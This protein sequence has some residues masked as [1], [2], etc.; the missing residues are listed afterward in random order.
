MKNINSFK[1]FESL[2][3]DKIQLLQD[4]SLELEDA[5]LQVEVINGT[6]THLLRDPRVTIHSGSKYSSDYK[7]YI[8]MRITDDNELFNADLYFTDTIQDF[9]ETLKSYGMNPRGM[10]GGRNFALIKFDKWGKMTG[11][12]FKSNPIIESKWGAVGDVQDIQHHYSIYDWFEDLKS[13]QW[14][15]KN[16]NN[17]DL[18]KWSDHF[19]GSGV[20]QKISKL[21][22]DIFNSIRSVDYN[23]INDRMLE[24]W[25]ELPTNKD[26]YVMACVAY[27]DYENLDK[28]IMYR[29]NGLLSVMNPSDDS[30]KLDII[31]HIIKDIIYPTLFIG[32]PSIPLR[33]TEEQIYVTDKKW[34]CE[35][36]DI[37]SYEFNEGEEFDN[38]GTGRRSTTTIF[39]SELD[40]K[41]NYEVDKVISM[42]KPCLVIEIGGHNDSHRTGK[43][44][45]SHLEPILDDVL[46]TILPDLDYEEVIWDKSRGKRQ[47]TDDEFYD[48]TLKI[49]LK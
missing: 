4:L 23:Y 1:I 10:S 5:G 11:S 39:K 8:I 13:I 24:V 20:Y 36:F 42:Y 21:V 3:D 25:D 30:K 12:Y 7:K 19:I 41:K 22:D 32:S 40:K 6:H 17:S 35:N 15:R 34:N 31:I 37:D 38:G 29:Y 43:I 9:I 49:L 14:N 47:F 46:E 44:K 18:K 28:E 16:V 45:L 33:R 2:V 26:K 48:Y 27:G